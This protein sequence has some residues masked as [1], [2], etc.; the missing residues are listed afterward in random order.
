MS[1]LSIDLRFSFV[2]YRNNVTIIAVSLTTDLRKIYQN[3]VYAVLATRFGERVMM[4]DFGSNLHKAAFEN[5]ESA[6]EIAK[7]SIVSAFSRW[8]LELELK[9]I[10]PTF[11]PNT[12]KLIVEVIYGLPN[13]E[14]DSLTI[15]TGIFNRTGDLILEINNG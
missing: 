2:K 12:N 1:N 7:E 8:L 9:E 5:S 6:V 15:N 14:T 4:P 3:R 11:D 13:S 10:N